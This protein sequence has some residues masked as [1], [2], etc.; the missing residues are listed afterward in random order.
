M[1]FPKKYS[2]PHTNLDYISNGLYLL[3]IEEV[4]IE[5]LVTDDGDKEN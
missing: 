3:G 2:I 5:T 1:D 4:L